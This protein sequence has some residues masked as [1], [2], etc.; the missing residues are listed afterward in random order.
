[1]WCRPHLHSTVMNLE[2][3]IRF[4][5]A[6]KTRTTNNIPQF[7]TFMSFSVSNFTMKQKKTRPWWQQIAV[8]HDAPSSN[9]TIGKKGAHDRIPSDPTISRHEAPKGV[10]WDPSR[11]RQSS[12]IM[13]DK[14]L[15]DLHI[16]ARGA[17][18]PLSLLGRT[19]EP[20][21][22]AVGAEQ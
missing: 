4:I 16:S 18:G 3:P 20:T 21:S 15:A 2:S 11:T 14:H 7:P 8:I 10:C 12:Q 1:M 6:A 9:R 22:A 19:G 13:E 5:I 17:L